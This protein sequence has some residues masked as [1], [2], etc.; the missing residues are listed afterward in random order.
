ME[1][2]QQVQEGGGRE[3]G[4]RTHLCDWP[5]TAAAQTGE[6]IKKGTAELT[7]VAA[8]A[9]LSLNSTEDHSRSPVAAAE[10]V[11]AQIASQTLWESKVLESIMPSGFYSMVP[12]KSFKA[13]CPT[14]PTLEEL[15]QLGAEAA[16][17]DVLLVDTHKDK[18]LANLEEFAKVL[19]NGL[20][21]NVALAIKKIAELVSNFYGGPL[22]E[23]GATKVSGDECLGSGDGC[24]IQLLGGV[25]TGLCRPRAI[26][27]KFLGDCVG[28]QSRLQMV[29]VYDILLFW[30]LK[31]YVVCG[32]CF[33]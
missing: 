32:E 13:S 17:S 5:P 33:I 3:E 27:F 15:E 28:I 26:L 30:F 10:Q 7:S 11:S 21:G 22:F 29:A 16:G 20:R 4:L 18:T 2:I 23:T 9:N 19:V 24:H 12:S 1:E 25:K 14:I 6:G 31:A 8:A